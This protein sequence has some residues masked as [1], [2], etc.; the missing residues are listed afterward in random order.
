M[1]SLTDSLGQAGALQSGART[2]VVVLFGN[3]L[4]GMI[5]EMHWVILLLVLLIVA[6]F[7][8]G[9][10]ESAK[11]YK[12]A[13]KAGDGARMELYRWHTSRALR[14]TFNKLA[15]YAVMMFLLGA[16]GMALLEPLGVSHTWGTWA[17]AL[18][19]CFCELTSIGGHFFYLRG[20]A[21][22]KR[23]IAGLLKAFVVAFVKK[24]NADAGEA[25]EESLTP[26]PSPVERGATCGAGGD[27]KRENRDNQSNQSN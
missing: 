10:G 5:L 2:T 21:V 24:K 3:D 12:E 1:T 17:A 6:D 19:A 18:I 23:T 13:E 7:R 25:L 9:W 14:R 16:V 4:A 26:H 20:V 11:R 22:E 27:G 8:Y 15:D